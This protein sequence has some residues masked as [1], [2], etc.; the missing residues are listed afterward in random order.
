MPTLELNT[1]NVRQ[2]L[3]ELGYETE[4]DQNR[5]RARHE[6]LWNVIVAVD[7][8]AEEI[9]M[10]TFFGIHDEVLATRRDELM[11]AIN[12]CNR[13]STICSFRIDGDGDL[14]INRCL[15]AMG[16]FLLRQFLQVIREG[17]REITDNLR[18]FLRDMV[19]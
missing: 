5:V 9:N 16:G 6:E 12:K 15:P 14:Y 8:V 2:I 13:N 3:D 10:V 7:K 18:R 17:D 4:V 11:E 19:Q 1:G